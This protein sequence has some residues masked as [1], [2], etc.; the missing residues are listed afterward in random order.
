M[1]QCADPSNPIAPIGHDLHLALCCP[2]PSGNPFT[3]REV[4]LA[5]R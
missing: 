3:R 2:A 1:P 5:I 4:T